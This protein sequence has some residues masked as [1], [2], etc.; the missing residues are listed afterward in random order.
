LFILKGNLS[1]LV[2]SPLKELALIWVPLPAC[3]LS[4]SLSQDKVCV[5]LLCPAVPGSGGPA[6]CHLC[7]ILQWMDSISG[8]HLLPTLYYGLILV[9][10]IPTVTVDLVSSK[11]ISTLEKDEHKILYEI[12]NTNSA[13]LYSE[14]G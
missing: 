8:E 13:I 10:D 1:G 7:L 2:F 12:N 14:K 4:L 11:I 9:T 6:L 5:W 3:P